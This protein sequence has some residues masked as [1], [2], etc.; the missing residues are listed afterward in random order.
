MLASSFW[1]QILLSQSRVSLCIRMVEL[2][3]CTSQKYQNVAD[4]AKPWFNYPVSGEYVCLRSWTCQSIGWH[5]DFERLFFH[6]PRESPNL[7]SYLVFQNEWLFWRAIYY[8]AY[9]TERTLL[10]KFCFHAQ[11]QDWTR[12]QCWNAIITELT[13]SQ[14][15]RSLVK[16]K[17]IL[18]PKF[19][20]CKIDSFFHN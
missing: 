17:I 4:V 14:Y 5:N 11:F 16:I 20:L 15:S 8:L 9:A 13:T 7:L 10:L 3:K 2:K 12:F 6:F 19:V 1:P 18:S